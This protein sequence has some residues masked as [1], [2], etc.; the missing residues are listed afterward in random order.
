MPT[1][2]PGISIGKARELLQQT[3]RIIARHPQVAHVLGKVGRAETATDSA[4]LTMIETTVILKDQESWPDGKRIEDITRELDAMVQLPGVSN[5]WTMPI[6]TRI[7][8]LATGIKTPV[9]IKLLGDDLEVLSSV[10]QQI[11]GVVKQLPGTTSVYSERVVGGNYVDIRIRREEAARYGLNV[12]DVQTVIGSA[13]GGMNITETVEGLARYPVNLRFPRELRND[14]GALARVAVSTPLGHTVPLAQVAD[15]Q[16]TTGPPSIKSENARRSAW[17][18][19]G[20]DTSDIGGYVERAR[21]VVESRVELPPGVSIVWSGQYEFMQR[22][23]DRLRLVVPLT[24]GIIFVLLYLH[25][26]RVGSTLIVMV[27]TILFA[28]IGGVW[29]LYWLDFNL[30]IAAWVGFIA[31]AGLAAETAIV[32]LVYLDQAYDRA[33]E[34]GR[35]EC[36]SD[37][38]RA[39]AEGTVG[40]VRPL[41]MTVATTMIGLLPIMFGSETGTRVMKRIAAP[42]VGGLFSSLVLTLVVLPA[43]YFLWKQ[44]SLGRTHGLKGDSGSA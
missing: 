6:K 38:R 5:A 9:G 16:V 27:S 35:M 24:L 2:P 28:P 26:R 10:G 33:V 20:L 37:L 8:M 42:M 7:D 19:V 13:I 3:D 34:S 31:L 15:I 23:N 30:S 44:R 18:F 12:A 41:V 14:L 1:T 22:A 40:R 25:F 21:E 17:I 4:P 11:E 32:M 39:I 36:A 29:L 43:I